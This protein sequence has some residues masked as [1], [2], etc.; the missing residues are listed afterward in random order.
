MKNILVVGAAWVGDAILSQPLFE[1][2][3]VR[4]GEG[5]LDVLAPPW[6]HGVLQRIE[7]IDQIIDLPFAH[8]VLDLSG[9]WRLARQ[10]RATYDQAIVL[11]NSIKSALIPW[12]AG[13]PQRTGYLGE[14]RWGLLNDARRL[15]RQRL[16]LMGQRFLALADPPEATAPVLPSPRLRVDWNN[17][18]RLL[19]EQGLSLDR[20]VAI[21]C[22]GAEF[23]PAKRWP[24]A[25]F[26]QVAQSWI[27]DGWQIWLMGS[28]KDRKIADTIAAQLPAR[29]C[30]PLCGVTTLADAVDLMA[31]GQRVV[32][33]DSGLMHLAAALD[34]PL[35]AL[36][37]SSSPEF[38][39]PLSSVARVFRV[40]L[41]CSPCFQ[42]ECP[43]QHLH[44]LTQLDPQSVIAHF[45]SQSR[46]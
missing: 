21:L 41:P 44:C 13:I 46:G 7:A 38:T 2:L 4:H 27:A 12:F 25:H 32:T 19:K 28:P 23:G 34:R 20:P 3:R 6:T 26:V 45:K 43:L 37:G 29:Y 39:P 31:L 17:Q 10:L 16:P 1:R 5:K 14:Q 11:P 42:R 8:G 15:D 40:G 35:A 36:F 18:Q 33:N 30:R 9:R 22:P 24:A